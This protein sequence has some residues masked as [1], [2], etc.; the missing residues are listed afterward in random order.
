MHIKN[1][2]ALA[3]NAYD[4]DAGEKNKTGLLIVWIGFR[5]VLKNNNFVIF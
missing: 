5:S 3:G 1:Y 2:N 4:K